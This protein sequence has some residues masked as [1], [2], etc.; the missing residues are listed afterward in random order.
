MQQKS[1]PFEL[2]DVTMRAREIG[3][4][5]Y[6]VMAADVDEADHT[7]TNAGFVV[8]ASGVL[9]IESL[10]NGRLASQ[11]IGEVRKITPA[12]IR[13]LVNTSFHGDHCFGNF[14][15]PSQTVI[16]HHEATKRTIEERFEQDREFMIGLL[17]A[18]EGIEEVVPRSADITVTE[19]CSVDLGGKHVDIAYIGFCQTEGDLVVRVREDNIIFVGNALQAPPPAFPWL[20]DGRVADSLATYRRLYEMLD[21]DTLIVPG[22]GGTM[23]RSDILHS[24]SYIERLMSL[25][26]DA[27]AQGMSHEQIREALAMNEYS[28]YSM[29]DF[30]HFDVN[31]P[32]ALAE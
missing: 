23:H 24:I 31:V 12:P 6:A 30:I 16:I 28:D 26:R 8:G 21:D 11:V 25:A 10:S 5:V 32:A 3:D 14:A 13:F 9:V 1:K 17:G 20:L 19:S 29:Y 27:K 15:F 22:H 4:S 2:A 7:A 18:D